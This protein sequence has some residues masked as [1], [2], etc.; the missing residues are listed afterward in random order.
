MGRA[1]WPAS[2]GG[3]ACAV[4]TPPCV[5][6][7]HRRS[8]LSGSDCRPSQSRA[9]EA[10]QENRDLPKSECVMPVPFSR[11][12]A[13]SRGSGRARCAGRQQ[14]RASAP[15]VWWSGAKRRERGRGSRG[16]GGVRGSRPVAGARRRR[17]SCPKPVS[18]CCGRRR[19]RRRRCRHPRACR[20]S[21]CT[22][23]R[24]PH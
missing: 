3:F 22:S 13:V 12:P 17:V 14:K 5:R 16:Q 1:D 18:S 10:Y 6:P 19:C 20:T 9:T 8:S 2:P 7:H 11:W 15:L 24:R 21:P 23:A 4:A